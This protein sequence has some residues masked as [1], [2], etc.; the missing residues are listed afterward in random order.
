MIVC[1]LGVSM[2]S[3]IKNK[4]AF[5][6][7][8]TEI[9]YLIIGVI[10]VLLIINFITGNH[11][12]AIVKSWLPKFNTT[13]NNDYSLINGTDEV[14][15]N[16]VVSN[17]VLRVI[18][19]GQENLV[20]ITSWKDSYY[21]SSSDCYGMAKK[22][23]LIYAAPNKEPEKMNYYFSTSKFVFKRSYELYKRNSFS[24]DEIVCIIIVGEMIPLENCQNIFMA[25]EA[26][27]FMLNE[28]GSIIFQEKKSASIE[29]P[30]VSSKVSSGGI[31]ITS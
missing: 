1:G 23:C 21:V 3:I 29:T 11:F 9:M 6:M 28:D 31:I 13:A 20:D 19:P 27:T 24:K 5:Q 10:I 8:F 30:K 7:G 18:K 12:G 4:K 17:G 25:S 14:V 15:P 16:V 26:E 2:R 22:Y